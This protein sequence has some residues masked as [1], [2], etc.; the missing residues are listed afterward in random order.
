MTEATKT[1]RDESRRLDRVKYFCR[2][3]LDNI[4]AARQGMAAA[5]EAA[6]FFPRG[7][8]VQQMLEAAG[9]RARETRENILEEEATRAKEAART[10][11]REVLEDPNT[12]VFDSETTGLHGDVDFL[13]IGVVNLEGETLFEE[14]MRPVSYVEEVDGEKV[15][16]GPIVCSDGAQKVHG[17]TADD[18]RDAP[19]FVQIYPELV[20]VLKDRRVV[21]YNASY[22]SGVWRQAVERYRLSPDGID[23][24]TWGCA[25]RAYAG[26]RGEYRYEKDEEGYQ[27]ST[28]VSFRWHRLG[29]SHGAVEDCRAALKLLYEIAG[30]ELPEALVPEPVDTLE[31][32]FDSIPF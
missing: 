8:E 24:K 20:E 31:Q 16:R 9:R 12:V 30:R 18:L 10:W 32:D 15:R 28:P 17:I 4:E 21:V 1:K 26:F 23:P 25:M 7:D 13:E 14:R 29:G 5:H 3:D 27:T 22:D 2:H 11:A 19:S 6:R